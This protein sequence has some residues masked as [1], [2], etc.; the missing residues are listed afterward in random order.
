MKTI[1]TS[2]FWVRAGR[3]NWTL[4]FVVLVAVLLVAVG[5]ASWRS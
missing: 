3:G 2:G 1:L 5:G 4:V